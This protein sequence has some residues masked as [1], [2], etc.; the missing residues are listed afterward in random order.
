MVNENRSLL[1]G[2]AKADETLIGGQ[3]STS[4]GEAVEGLA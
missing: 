3:Q 1:S 2:L 4:T